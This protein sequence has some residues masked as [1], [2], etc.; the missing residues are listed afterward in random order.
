MIKK[1]VIAASVLLLGVATAVAQ[2]YPRDRDRDGRPD[3]R[4]GPPVAR[5]LPPP[6][7]AR[8]SVF[9]PLPS[10][11][12]WNRGAFPYEARYHDSCQRKAW[13][14]NWFERRAGS[15]GVFTWSER[16]ELASLRRDLDRT[17]GGWRWRG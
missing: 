11:T 17:C 3:Y 6:P 8:R 12:V 2:P 1:L 5:P 13:R 16:R 7:V 9:A 4:P 15:D 10:V 14:L